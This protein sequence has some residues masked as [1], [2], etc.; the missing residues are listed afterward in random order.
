MSGYSTL[1]VVAKMI[2]GLVMTRIDVIGI[3]NPRVST[4]NDIIKEFGVPFTVSCH[5]Y[6][7]E[8]FPFIIRERTEWEI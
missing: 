8:S 4:T 3:G 6:V 5:Q 7:R 2:K 1:L